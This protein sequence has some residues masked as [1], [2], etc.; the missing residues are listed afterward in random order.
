MSSFQSAP[1]VTVM[2][3][4]QSQLSARR[5]RAAT[6]AESTPVRTEW[7]LLLNTG[8]GNVFPLGRWDLASTAMLARAINSNDWTEVIAYANVGWVPELAN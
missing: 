8:F 7:K 2:R 4:G 3:G 5:A 1:R 6:S